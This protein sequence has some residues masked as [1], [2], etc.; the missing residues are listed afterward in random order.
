V[1]FAEIGASSQEGGEDWKLCAWPAVTEVASPETAVLGETAMVAK[2]LDVDVLDLFV[3]RPTNEQKPGEDECGLRIAKNVNR[4][5][6]SLALSQETLSTASGHFRT[7]V[8]NLEHQRGNPSVK[9]LAHIAE[10]LGVDIPRLLKPL[11]KLDAE[12]E[13]Q[14]MVRGARSASSTDSDR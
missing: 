11:S 9:D 7:Y 5:R 8:G 1:R 4:L 2:A 6:I 3:E 12:G 13:M 10:V 14:S